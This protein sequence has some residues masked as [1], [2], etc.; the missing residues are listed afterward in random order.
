MKHRS[1][2][3]FLLSCCILSG[4]VPR[5]GQV[6][7]GSELVFH[8]KAF[9]EQST[10]SW[11][12]ESNPKDGCFQA[13]RDTIQQL[14]HKSE[15]AL[16]DSRVG[17][18]LRNYHQAFIMV[19]S[20]QPHE[21]MYHRDRYDSRT[22]LN[23]W[24]PRRMNYILKDLDFQVTNEVFRDTVRT[25]FLYITWRDSPV[26]NLYYLYRMKDGWSGLIEAEHGY[27]YLRYFGNQS[28]N[29]RYGRIKMDLKEGKGHHRR[30][31]PSDNRAQE[32]GDTL[33]L[34]T[35]SIPLQKE[36]NKRHQRKANS[37]E[38]NVFVVVEDMPTFRG[39][40]IHKFRE[41]V[42]KRLQY[43]RKA[44]EQKLEG[45]V[46]VRFTID[47]DGAVAEVKIVRGVDPLLD[48][49][50]LRVIWNSPLWKVGRQ[51]G[52]PVQV[53]FTIPVQFEL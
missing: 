42:Q 52:R 39:G 4:W 26:K 38:R 44:R 34:R 41:Y 25:I 18:A 21:Q 15:E 8:Q 22:P 27:G 1:S 23:R 17:D 47:T 13:Y 49:E 20:L 5:P 43:P 36:Q 10:A 6:E 7:A 16:K 46:F 30:K 11:R 3:F 31:L 14:I 32:Q 45:E 48:K 29:I 50:A 33:S 19:S 51:R 9:L 2:L 40:G 53:D 35:I 12:G 37:E 24:I 28:R